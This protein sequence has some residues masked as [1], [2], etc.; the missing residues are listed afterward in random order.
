MIISSWL[1]LNHGFY[2]LAFLRRWCEIPSQMSNIEDDLP[3]HDVFLVIIEH[4][5][6][7]Q[8]LPASTQFFV[9]LGIEFLHPSRQLPLLRRGA[10]SVEEG[11]QP[12]QWSAKT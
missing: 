3:A 6:H 4:L 11:A 9:Y 5:A 1:L 12:I 7:R 8:G 2:L 10:E